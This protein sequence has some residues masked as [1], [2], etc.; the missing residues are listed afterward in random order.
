MNLPTS[1]P[2]SLAALN[3][4]AI[5][6]LFS[7]GVLLLFEILSATVYLL[8]LAVAA[9]VGAAAALSGAGVMLQVAAFAGC[10]VVGLL[11]AHKVRRLIAGGG[12]KGRGCAQTSADLHCDIG[13]WVDVPAWDANGRAQ[14]RHRGTQWSARIKEG[15]ERAPGEH[16]ITAVD[17]NEI[18]LTPLEPLG[19]SSG[20]R[21]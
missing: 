11:V 16:R 19:S 21:I 6:W 20:S 2:T 14:V 15:C 3:D 18:V 9:C 4:P 13:M 7:A 1:L 8:V 12:I 17:G 5:T 10:A